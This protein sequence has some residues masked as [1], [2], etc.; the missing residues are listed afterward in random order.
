MSVLTFDKHQD[1]ALAMNEAKLK[2]RHSR[3]ME[4][5]SFCIETL[6]IERPR[7]QEIGSVDW[8]QTDAGARQGHWQGTNGSPEN[9]RQRPSDYPYRPIRHVDPTSASVRETRASKTACYGSR[10]PLMKSTSV[11]D[12]QPLSSHFLSQSVPHG[13]REEFKS[14][15]TRAISPRPFIR[16]EMV[17]EDDGIAD[18]EGDLGAPE[19]SLC[20]EEYMDEGA[21]VPRNLQCGH[22]FCT[23]QLTQIADIICIWPQIMISRG[24]RRS[25]IYAQI[26]YC[27]TVPACFGM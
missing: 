11:A 26:Y 13:H 4:D 9:G 2:R 3:S 14:A 21:R 6:A 16:R 1:V 10:R 5:V 17:I 20:M 18:S 27:I 15:Q 12:I 19:C 25:I 7:Q 22:T 23:G 24:S 8:R